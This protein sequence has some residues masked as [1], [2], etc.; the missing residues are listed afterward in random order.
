MRAVLLDG[1]GTLLRL[2]DPAPHLR[3][4]LAARGVV[5]DAST[6]RAGMAAEIAYYREH[7]LEGADPQGLAGLRRRCAEVL[8]G[9]LAVPQDASPAVHD[10]LLA[11]LRFHAFPD[12]IPALDRLRAAGLRL[13]V[14]SNWD[15]SLHE[16]LAETG[17]ARRLD[18]A[19]TS[20]EVGRAKPDPAV[21][22]RAL[23]I[24]GAT[25]DEALHVGD[26]R[27]E[28]VVGARNAGIEPVLVD[29]G[30]DKGAVGVRTISSLAELPG[31]VGAHP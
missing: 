2:E 10:A 9:A 29:R 11:A 8:R 5:V 12:A 17:L 26:S 13:V 28:D 16:R 19:V 15:V 24:A 1:M 31:L 25:A 7:N 3:R 4:E 6:A 27:S 30:G 20:A 23:E 21:F 14:A 22:A 18:G